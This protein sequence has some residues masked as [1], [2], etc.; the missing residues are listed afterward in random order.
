MLI[1][2][3][4]PELYSYPSEILFVSCQQLST[5]DTYVVCLCIDKRKVMGPLSSLAVE[6]VSFFWWPEDF[7]KIKNNMAMFQT[8]NQ[9]K[10]IYNFLLTLEGNKL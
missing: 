2:Q 1:G 7:Q 10:L 9:K 3:L 4:G 8:P 5:T 6:Y